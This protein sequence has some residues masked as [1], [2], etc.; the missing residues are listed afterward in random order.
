MLLIDQGVA[1]SVVTHFFID[2]LSDYFQK[3]FK[4]PSLPNQGPDIFTECPP[5]GGG[6][7]CENFLIQAL[8]CMGEF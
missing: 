5:L 6:L 2:Y 4:T 7:F 3:I 1:Q 8:I